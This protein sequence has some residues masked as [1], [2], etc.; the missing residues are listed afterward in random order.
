MNRFFFPLPFTFSITFLFCVVYLKFKRQEYG[1]KIQQQ[2]QQALPAS[3][4]YLKAA[5][6]YAI[7]SRTIIEW[8]RKACL[9]FF[10]LSYFHLQLLIGLHYA[11]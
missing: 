9:V 1:L 10:S 2:Q 4:K 5:K 11:M 3:M 7:L 8:P 6:K